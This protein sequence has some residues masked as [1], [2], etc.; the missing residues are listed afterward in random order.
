[1]PSE[2]QRGRGA[3]HGLPDS[4]T[5]QRAARRPGAKCRPLN[6]TVR[7]RCCKKDGRRT[8]RRRTALP[9]A[10][11]DERCEGEQGGPEG[12]CYRAVTGG[13]PHRAPNRRPHGRSQM[14]GRTQVRTVWCSLLGGS[15]TLNCLIR[16]HSR[17]AK[18]CSH[19]TESHEIPRENMRRGHRARR[20]RRACGR[21]CVGRVKA[22]N[23]GCRA[24][25]EGGR[26]GFLG[27]G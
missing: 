23:V 25:R 8:W 17:A 4:H 18:L 16:G 11:D 10:L 24:G 14:D 9:F 27:P 21:R 15:G 3:G 20:M 2:E 26:Q 5:A 22:A 6:K 13:R 1:M 7:G 12:R 19:P